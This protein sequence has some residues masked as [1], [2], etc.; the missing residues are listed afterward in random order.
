VTPSPVENPL[1]ILRTERLILTRIHPGHVP[2]LVDLWMDPE[3]TRFMG[4]PREHDFL[5]AE[6]EKNTLAPFA[7]KHDLWALVEKES[8]AVVGHCGLLDKEVEGTAEIELVYVLAT[9]AWG[10]GYGTEIAAALKE[11]AFQTLGLTRLISLIEPENAAS[12]RVAVK[13]GMR[14]E[15]EVNRPEGVKRRVYAVES[16]SPIVSPSV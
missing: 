14:L 6:F 8:G 15:R 5:A 2:A 7:E 12:E 13:T 16:V 4:G 9:A 10:K 3:V 11:Y 1:E